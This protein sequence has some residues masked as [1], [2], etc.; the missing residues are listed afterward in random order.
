MSTMTTIMLMP[1]KATSLQHFNFKPSTL[2]SRSSPTKSSYPTVR[3]QTRFHRLIEDQGIVLMPGCYDAL[4]AAIVQQSGFTAGFISGYALSASLLGKPDFGLLTP[5]E[6]AATARTVCAAAPMIPIIADADT[7]GGNAL[8]V[9]RTVR[10]L[11]AAG[12]AGCFLEDQAWPKKCGHMCGKQVIPAEEHAAKI[13]SAR[14]AIGDSDFFLVARTDAGATS[15]KTG[16]SDAIARAN[17]YMEAG[18]DACFV[19]APRNDDELKEIGRHT[20]GYRVCNMIEG[21]V[22]PLHTPEELRAMGFHLIVHPLTA[23]YASARALVDVL[24]TLKENGTTRDHLHKMATFEEFNQLVKLDSW[25]ELEARY[26]NQK[27]PMRV[28]S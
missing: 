20:K 25:F 14:D 8:N 9:Q 1:P 2:R 19:E 21:G 28:K 5:T 7:G 22:T 17:L 13:A 3:M 23:L 16:L 10:D 15:A 6:M 24:R 26:S 4:S 12:A 18:A 11:I 27:S